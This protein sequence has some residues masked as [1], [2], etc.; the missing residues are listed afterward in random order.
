MQ[1]SNSKNTKSE[2][3]G[4]ERSNEKV[5]TT[6]LDLLDFEQEFYQYHVPDSSRYCHYA[7]RCSSDTERLLYL[8]LEIRRPYDMDILPQVT[9]GCNGKSVTVDFI[10]SLINPATWDARPLLVVECDGPEHKSKL[11]KRRDRELLATHGLSVVRFTNS[12]IQRD[13]IECAEQTI[14]VFDQIKGVLIRAVFSRETT[15]PGWLK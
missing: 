11:D 14:R 7:Q 6:K 2:D 1:G 13:A 5:V 10:I 3:S 15:N 4:Q 9:M 12:E 8:H